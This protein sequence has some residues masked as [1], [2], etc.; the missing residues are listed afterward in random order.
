[1]R[2]IPGSYDLQHCLFPCTLS[3]SPIRFETIAPFFQRVAVILIKDKWERAQ[4]EAL[5]AVEFH[6]GFSSPLGAVGFTHMGIKVN[7][8]GLCWTFVML[9]AVLA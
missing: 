4:R 1:M 9:L 3:D 5:R 7:V 6:G 8:S 2:I